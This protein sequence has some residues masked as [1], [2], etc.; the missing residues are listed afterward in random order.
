ML[1]NKLK[2][3]DILIIKRQFQFKDVCPVSFKTNEWFRSEWRGI[4][5]EGDI[6]IVAENNFGATFNQRYISIIYD[7]YGLVYI[8]PVYPITNDT[9]ELI[10]K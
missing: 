2:T 5:V 8:K 4:G 3:N 6:V 7:K 10:S 1:L 9:F